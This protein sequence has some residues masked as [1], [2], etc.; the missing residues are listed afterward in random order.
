[1]Q[2]LLLRQAL[3]NLSISMQLMFKKI[4]ED[5]Q[6]NQTQIHIKNKQF[7]W[8][9]HIKL[10]PILEAKKIFAFVNNYK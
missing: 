6:D 2:T 8:I 1:M 4:K 5:N 9:N 3:L 7:V 10:L